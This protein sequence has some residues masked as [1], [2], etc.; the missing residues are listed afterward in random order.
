MH[1]ANDY[2]GHSAVLARYCGLSGRPPRIHGYLQHGWN[3]GDGMAADHEYVAG[4]PLFLW[5]ERTRRRAWSLGRRGTYVV[6]APWA[7]LLRQEPPGPSPQ[8]REGTIW[9]PFHGWEGQH[10]HGD[11]DRLIARIRETEGEAVTVC[12]YWQ[13][14]RMPR[15]RRRYE[16]AGFR[17]VCHGYR[18]DPWQ[19]G[20]PTFL[21]H[22]LAEL[23]RHRRVAS[24]RLST[25]VWYGILAGCEPAVYGDPMTLSGEDPR[26]GGQARIRRQWAPLHGERIDPAV[27]HAAA[28]EELGADRLLSPAEL[29]R[30]FRWTAGPGRPERGARS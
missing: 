28:V 10:V 2:Y 23:R 14:Y 13:E 18:G 21:R 27:A 24:N 19:P 4:V 6:G 17:V 15:L 12:L 3:I 30:V 5:S 16:R 1:R 25:A 22:Q 29:R 7:Y 11:H 20:D 8:P 26:F 9:Y